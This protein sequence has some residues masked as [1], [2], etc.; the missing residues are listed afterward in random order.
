MSMR[1]SSIPLRNPA[2]G[3]Q[4]DVIDERNILIS[5]GAAWDG[6]T[7]EVY[8]FRQLDTPEFQVLQNHV[9]LHLSSLAEIELKVNGR[10]DVRI[11]APG[12]LS[13]F[14]C[15]TVCCARSQEAHEVL[16]VSVSPQVL[17]NAGFEY[18]DFSHA[19]LQPRPYLLDPQI[20]QICRALKLE[21]ESNYLSGPLYGEALGL[22]FSSRLL[23]R[24]SARNSSTRRSGG[25]GPQALR[26][27]VD[28]IDSELS[29]PLRMNSLA[30]VAGLSQY[31]FAHNFKEHTGL[32]PYKYVLRARIEKAK[33]ML[34]DTDL[35]IIE[36][37][38]AVGFQSLSQ[39]NSI[40]KRAMGT[41][42]SSFRICFR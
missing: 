27:V 17:S 21:A 30:Q 8:S 5:S 31:R 23:T 35:P 1:K 15:G 37:A 11:R 16:V 33:R 29:S 28:Y 41:T 38:L 39:F 34:K 19:E 13:L 6:V 18:L 7:A 9:V 26:R 25:L 20:E 24:Y 14:P 12:S 4:E 32:P 2:T 36:I 40:F 10:P 42:P 3:R 22:A